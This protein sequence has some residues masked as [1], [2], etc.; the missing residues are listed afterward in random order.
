MS[1]Q[2]RSELR[3]EDME[4]LASDL[5]EEACVP[6]ILGETVLQNHLEFCLDEEDEIYEG[7]GKREYAYPYRQ[8]NAYSKAM[9]K[10]IIRTIV[11]E[12][13][14]LKAVFLPELGGRLWSLIDKETGRNLLYTNDVLRFRN[15]AVRNAWFSGG[16]EWNIG[17]IGHTPFTTAP[18][19]AAELSD[20]EGNPVLRMYEYERIRRV[21]YQMDF[22]LGAGDRVLNCRMRIVNENDTVIPMYWWSNMAVP[23]YAGGRVIVPARKAFTVADGKVTKVGIPYVNGVDVTRYNGIPLSVDYFFDIEEE[24][25][26][27]IAST[28]KDGYG[29]LQVSTSRLRSR[30]L[31]SWGH[32]RGSKHWQEFLTKDGGDYIEIQAGLAKTQYGCLPM[33]PHTAWEWM[34]QYG[35]LQL[36]K[37]QL[38]LSNEENSRL[39]TEELCRSGRI[40]ELEMKLRETKTLAKTRGSLLMKGSGYGAFAAPSAP[41]QE[42]TKHLEFCMEKES[43]QKWEAFCRTGLLHEPEPQERPDEF[44]DED[45]IFF[46]LKEHIKDKNQKNWYAHYQLGIQYY[47]RKNDKKAKKELKESWKWKENPW[48]CHGLSCLY[49]KAGRKEKAVSWMIRGLSLEKKDVSYLKEGF[50]ILFAGQGYEEIR[51]CYESLGEEE[52]E[53]S[54]LKFYDIS[55]RYQL[56]QYEEALALL[57]QDGGLEL[58]DVREGEDSIERLWTQLQEASGREPREVPAP[59]VFRAY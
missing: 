26:K 30:K 39:L 28:D 49:L 35:P 38:P 1:S 37:E 41:G 9:R 19:Y 57:E 45:A 42:G 31:F 23:E 32:T 48:A 18:L 40:S 10:R 5:G 55:A 29:L 53:I 15:L 46:L 34:E 4:I 3:V 36:K 43:L 54:R 12:N 50:K 8:Y 11:L 58:E 13:A 6:D 47:V 22:W 27:Y 16:V 52:K 33:A 25:P 56:G 17:V 59:F 14:Y 51:Q 20:E 21:C 7:Y 44:W 2:R 24:S